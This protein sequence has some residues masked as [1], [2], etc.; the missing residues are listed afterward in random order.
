MTRLQG[1]D[2]SIVETKFGSTRFSGVPGPKFRA[3]RQA[4][5]L[6]NNHNNNNNTKVRTPQ[7]YS[8]QKAEVLIRK[9]NPWTLRPTIFPENASRNEP[10]ANVKQESWPSYKIVFHSA[11]VGRIIGNTRGRKGIFNLFNDH[12]RQ[13]E[14]YP[15]GLCKWR[16][17]INDLLLPI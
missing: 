3:Q 8:L 2:E 17:D 10:Q 12:L 7:H 15:I 9:C 5:K 11:V 4:P 16:W 13:T 1:S 14:K 6:L